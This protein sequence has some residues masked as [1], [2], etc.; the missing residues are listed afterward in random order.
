MWNIGYDLWLKSFCI[1]REFPQIQKQLNIWINAEN[2]T[3]HRANFKFNNLLNSFQMVKNALP[4]R[5]DEP[6]WGLII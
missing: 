2:R 3:F 1:Y 6:K 4:I 5:L